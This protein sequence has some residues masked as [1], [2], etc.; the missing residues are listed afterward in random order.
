[1]KL[2]I[3]NKEGKST[4]KEITLNDAI[5]GAEPNEHVVYLTVKQYLANQR[6]GTHSTLTRST[7]SGSTKKLHKQKGT[8]GSRKGSVKN[9]QYPGGPRAFGPHPHEYGFK[10]NS[11][12]KNLAKVSVLSAKAKENNICVI[13]EFDFATAKTK[14]YLE[15]LN[16][17]KLNGAKTLMVTGAVQKNV[18]LSSRNIEKA[19]TTTADTLNAYAIINAD[20]LILTVDAVKKI[21]E[22]LG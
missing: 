18:V 9:I 2:E 22:T 1:M 17:M 6:Q 21:E 8:G 15:F 7:V 11:K 19:A 4:G 3:L 20:K 16:S 14:Q 12:V 13:E 5:F 10:L